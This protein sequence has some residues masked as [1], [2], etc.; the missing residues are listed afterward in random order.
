LK[1]RV[2]E[3][4]VYVSLRYS[5]LRVDMPDANAQQGKITV[6]RVPDESYP[7]GIEGSVS[8]LRGKSPFVIPVKQEV[9]AEAAAPVEEEKPA[10][11]FFYKGSAVLQKKSVAVLEDSLRGETLFLSAGE[12]FDVFR[13][14]AFS[15]T[16]ATL[17][18]NENFLTVIKRE[19]Q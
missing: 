3:K 16:E 18:G 7:L 19:D 2:D 15:E 13:L 5:T 4:S 9:I 1:A 8:V 11:R 14:K 12:K 6:A 17:E 10:Q